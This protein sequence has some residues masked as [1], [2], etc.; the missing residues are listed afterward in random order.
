MSRLAVFIDADNF[1]D[2]TALDYAMQEVL[3]LGEPV[4][5]KYAYGNAASLKGIEVVLGKYGIRPIS[6]LIVGKTTTDVALAIGAMEAICCNPEIKLA[7]ICSGDADFAPLALRL[8]EKGCKVI[9]VGLHKNLFASAEAFY[10]DVLVIHVVDPPSVTISS[11]ATQLPQA[12]INAVKSPELAAVT[13]AFDSVVKTGK[14]PINAEVKKNIAPVVRSAPTAKVTSLQPQVAA[15]DIVQAV[16]KTCP[17]LR[18]GSWQHLSQ[19]VQALRKQGTLPKNAKSSAWFAKLAPNFELTPATK[20]N[21][22]RYVKKI[23]NVSKSNA[24]KKMADGASTNN[25][26]PITSSTSSETFSDGDFV[27]PGKSSN[28]VQ[29]TQPTVLTWHIHSKRQPTIPLPSHW[30]ALRQVLVQIAA[31][32]VSIADILLAAPE[33]L[34]GQACAYSAVASRLRE[35]NLVLPNQ[36]ILRILQCH[37]EAFSLDNAVSPQS[38]IYLGAKNRLGDTSPDAEIK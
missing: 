36:S 28:P 10:D 16:L 31:Q 33:L 15:S 8:R 23:Q 34:V 24:I 1:S 9:A 13:F 11:A 17:E 7:V 2:C 29:A 25:V 18:G 27:T 6:N 21:Q 35:R 38:L 30:N 37:P 4:S 5:L 14:S 22:V 26:P 3:G 12:A 32:R 20:P 19:I